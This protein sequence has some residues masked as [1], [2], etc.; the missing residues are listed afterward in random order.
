VGFRHGGHLPEYVLGQ[1]QLLAQGE[2]LQPLAGV[3]GIA[4][5]RAREDLLEAGELQVV[6]VEQAPTSGQHLLVQGT[7]VAIVALHGHRDRQ[8]APFRV[9]LHL[10][11]E[12]R[13]ALWRVVEVKLAR[14]ELA[15]DAD[16]HTMAL[17]PHIHGH[18][19]MGLSHGLSS[20]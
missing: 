17:H 5:G 14:Q 8:D 6:D 10:P 20:S 4:L 9:G 13:K 15:R 1:R 3:D 16:G 12:G 18:Q 19:H 7:S 11:E 2:E